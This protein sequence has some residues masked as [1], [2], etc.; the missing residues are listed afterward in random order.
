MASGVWTS[1]DFRVRRKARKLVRPHIGWGSTE[2]ART[3]WKNVNL[4]SQTVMLQVVVNTSEAGFQNTPFYFATLH[5]DFG[6]FKDSISGL[7]ASGP[8]PNNGPVT[9]PPSSCTFITD[10]EPAGFKFRIL[11]GERF[12]LGSRVSFADAEARNWTVSWVGF[13]P[14]KGCPPSLALTPAFLRLALHNFSVHEVNR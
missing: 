11:P 2:A 4:A 14:V 12:P 9:I 8:W 6:G 5:G 7:M 13:E 10:A 1:L 3:G